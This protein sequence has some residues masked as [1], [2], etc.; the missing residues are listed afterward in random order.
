MTERTF[1][2]YR[3]GIW[4]LL[5]R[6]DPEQAHRFTLTV[7]HLSECI[8]GGLTALRAAF[9]PP[10]D[11]RLQ[12][13]RF[14]LTFP[15]PLG[16]AAGL[17]K[18]AVAVGAWFALGFGFVEVGTVTPRPQPG[19]PRPRLWRI[20]EAG[21]LVNALGFPS[22]GAAAVR[23]RLVGRFF[24]GPL[25]INL[26]RNSQTP[27]ERALDDYCAVLAALWDVA[28]YVAVNV[29][30]P[31][32][33]GLRALQQRTALAE[34]VRVLQA[35]NQRLAALHRLR[36][37]PIL[38]KL[39]PDLSDADLEDALVGIMDGGADGVIIANTSLDRTLVPSWPAG[40]RGGI[41]GTPLRD[42]ALALTGRVYQRTNGRLPIIGVGGIASGA[43]VLER[44][45]AGA[46]LVQLYT[47]FIYGGPAVPARI[48]ADILAY[49]ERERIHSVE[50]LIG[51]G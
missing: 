11:D 33:P 48:L 24:P 37:R 46:S 47:G 49:L 38:V 3:R 39:A 14:G 18:D 1:S 9:H 8:P 35:E 20:P 44:L 32:T 30:S 21:A 6:L 15:N 34:L 31:N 16:L 29:S 27:N 43:D 23:A 13:H 45:R 50:Q 36:P 19:N 17:D 42:R 25:G 10:V 40:G 5:S 51:A 4:P 7:L 41:S 26:G 28:D 22:A 12:V 2:L